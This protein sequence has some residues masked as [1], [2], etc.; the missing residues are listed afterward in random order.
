M[1]AGGHHAVHLQ[2]QV[3][4]LLLCVP[5]EHLAWP[6]TRITLRMR[7]DAMSPA[8]PLRGSAPEERRRAWKVDD[9]AKDELCIGGEVLAH[10]AGCLDGCG[11]EVHPNDHPFHAHGA[12]L[13]TP[14]VRPE[15]V[16]P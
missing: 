3:G 11:A 12:L 10:P 2:T 5:G 13:W 9:M 6:P 15:A 16:G 4:A 14:C 1:D 8:K 7:P